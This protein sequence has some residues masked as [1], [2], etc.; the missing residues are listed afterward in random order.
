MCDCAPPVR[1]GSTILLYA[2]ATVCVSNM[3]RYCASRGARLTRFYHCVSL[4]SLQRV[5]RLGQIARHDL[6]PFCTRH[7]GV[8][9]LISYTF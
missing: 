7:G 9:F 3:H 5:A 8:L 4:S 2:D 6:F 1:K